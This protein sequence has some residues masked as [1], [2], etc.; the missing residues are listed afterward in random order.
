MEFWLHYDVCLN[1]FLGL[2]LNVIIWFLLAIV[3]V[4]NCLDSN[5]LVDMLVLKLIF[6]DF[7]ILFH[8]FEQEFSNWY[9]LAKRWMFVSFILGAFELKVWNNYH[10]LGVDFGAWRNPYILR[11]STW[12]KKRHIYILNPYIL[13]VSTWNHEKK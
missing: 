7:R 13:V 11:V 4:W 6:G 5:T 2:C 3:W 9:F 12:K 10:T 8:H 1:S